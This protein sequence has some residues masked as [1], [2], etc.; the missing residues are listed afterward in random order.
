MQIDVCWQDKP[1][2]GSSGMYAL[3]ANT[4]VGEQKLATQRKIGRKTKIWFE[5]FFTK[6][7]FKLSAA[8]KVK[9][10]KDFMRYVVLGQQRE[11]H[12]FDLT[13]PLVYYPAF[14][15]LEYFKNI[16]PL[17]ASALKN[18]GRCILICGLEGIGKTT[19]S[20]ELSKDAGGQ[21]FSDNLILHDD[22]HIYPCYEPIRI[23]KA[24]DI[25]LW[26]GRFKKINDFRALKDF[27]EPVDFDSGLKGSPD[28]VLIPAFGKEFSCRQM[29]RDE[30]VN[31]IL[32]IN[33]LTA[34]LGNYNEYAHL[35]SLMAA[36]FNLAQERFNTLNALINKATCYELI[37]RKSDGINENTRRAKEIIF[38]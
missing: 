14:W 17:H 6:D 20:L 31:K 8:L 38:S 13:Y 32:N 19:L 2:L 18:N 23:H 1:R 29:A 11:P 4:L 28:I 3:G 33:N 35:L 25:S 15:Y 24:E 9:P 12:F 16:H 27:Y 37:M 5:Y 21:F 26:Q 30:C 7:C 34:E 10:L 36:D 22:K